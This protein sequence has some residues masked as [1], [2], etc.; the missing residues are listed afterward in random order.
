M[1][2]PTDSAALAL[3][4]RAANQRT[5]AGHDAELLRRWLELWARLEPELVDAVAEVLATSKTGRV[6]PS[7]LIKAKRVA[8][9]LKHAHSEVAGIVEEYSAVV[10]PELPAQVK[11]MLEVHEQITAMQLPPGGVG[12][13][14]DQLNEG[15]LNQIVARS[16]EQITATHMALPA[17]VDEALKASLTRGIAVGENPAETAR[18]IVN[19]AKG[20]FTG[21]MA[22]ATMIARTEMLD[23]QRTAAA[24]WEKNNSQIL[25]GWVWV[26]ALDKRSCPSCVAMH[27]SVHPVDEQGP[28]D[29][30]NGRCAR[31]PKTKTWQELGYKAG[32]DT[33]PVIPTGEDLFNNMSETEQNQLIGATRANLVRTGR[34]QFADLTELRETPGWRPSHHMRTITDLERIANAR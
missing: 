32:K 9:A 1:P 18:R 23:A 25:D 6:R 27:G 11:A 14:F 21:G 20:R 3:E 8:Q 19:Q 22:R 28:N 15:A 33:R 30:Q 10:I 12:Y 7:R 29:H 34:I 24:Q 16:T 13:S 5:L 26:C 17:M 2:V 4:V 31:V